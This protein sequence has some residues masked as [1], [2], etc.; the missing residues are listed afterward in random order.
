ML[1]ALGMEETASR[2]LNDP[3]ILEEADFNPLKTYIEYINRLIGVIIGFLIIAL[4]L[5][6][7]KFR[8][9]RPL[10]FWVSVMTLITVLFQGWLGSIVVSTNLTSW[11]IT[12]HMFIAFVI[13]MLLVY[14]LH[15]S[16]EAPEKMNVK[17]LARYTMLC[18]IFLLIAQVFLGT[19]VRT[20]IDSLSDKL[21]ARAN[22][23]ESL[24]MEFLIHR[25]FSWLVLFTNLG[26]LFQLRKTTSINPL[27]IT[28]VL[29]ILLSVLTGVGMAYFNVPAFLQ[30]VHLMIATVAFGTQLLLFFRM[31][32]I[33]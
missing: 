4:F 14:L 33:N 9:N 19:E 28:V 3:T 22:W 10:L 21:I 26:L 25:S 24:G 17:P 6:S 27:S 13:V 7:I 23:I 20:A 32:P 8:K 29:L 1:S 16:G 5:S 15:Y 30:P 31:K 18:A 2:I 11:T 12:I